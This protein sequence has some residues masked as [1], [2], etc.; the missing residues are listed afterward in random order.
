MYRLGHCVDGEW[1][2]HSHAA[3]FQLPVPGDSQRIVLGLPASDVNV[4]VRLA[5]LL[6][7][8]LVLLYCVTRIHGAAL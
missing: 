6:S 3:T 4:I 7:E 5:R 1:V 2:E 8:P